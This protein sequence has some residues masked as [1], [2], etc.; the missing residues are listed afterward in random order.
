M[1]EGSG[2][3]TR[4]AGAASSMPLGTGEMGPEL[5]EKLSPEMLRL[6]LHQMYSGYA[7]GNPTG[8]HYDEEFAMDDWYGKR[9]GEIGSAYVGIHGDG[10]NEAVTVAIREANGSLAISDIE[11]GRP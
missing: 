2:L 7:D 8:I 9:H 3:V 11:W 5:K 6:K 4:G 1:I 10:W